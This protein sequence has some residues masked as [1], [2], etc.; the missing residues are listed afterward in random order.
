LVLAAG[1][2][3]RLR[4][5]TT[6]SEGFAVPKQF[7]SL[8]GGSSLLEETLL[9]AEAVA[10]RSRIVTV[11][12]AEHRRWW[13]AP[14]WTLPAEN[15]VVQPQNKG[16]ATGLLLPLLHILRRDPNATVAVLPSDHLVCD[17]SVLIHTLRQAM[18]LARTDD[19]C[20]YLLGAEPVQADAELGYIVPAKA[21]AIASAVRRF[22]EKP[23]A[24]VAWELGRTGALLNMFIMVAAA[25]AFLGL[26]ARKFASLVTQL[27][28]VV[29]QDRSCP[30]D[31]PAAERAYPTLKTLDFS[32]DILQGQESK[33]RVL[34][35][36]DCGWSDLG[37]PERV[38]EALARLD[39]VPEGVV[40]ESS[41]LNLE[42]Q[43]FRGRLEKSA[44]SA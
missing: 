22:V 11:V 21:G 39:A 3:T 28:E 12:A 26:Y 38:A 37:T 23:A 16:T 15:V 33:L 41:H 17:E 31:C 35:V 44:T 43:H 2:G 34:K 24:P 5:L 14:L 29:D 7:C 9:R 8:R 30:A 27:S 6:T 10:T 20:V 18:E 42:K 13:E 4:S 1:D 36:P 19:R 25:R 32:R 40:P